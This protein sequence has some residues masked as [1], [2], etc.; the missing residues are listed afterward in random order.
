MALLSSSV[1][2]N[3]ASLRV[4]APKS[5]TKIPRRFSPP[6]ASLSP[7]T[8]S[9]SS[10]SSASASQES[11]STAATESFPGFGNGT[12]PKAQ[13]YNYAFADLNG[14]PVVRFVQSTESTI[15]RVSEILRSEA[16]LF[17][18]L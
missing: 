7:P 9:P 8:P 1:S 18:F 5:S 14:D 16:P 13:P 10:N 11:T 6:L 4:F 15:E 12:P 17:I 3:L 2:P